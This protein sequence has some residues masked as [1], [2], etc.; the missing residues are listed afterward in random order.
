VVAAVDPY[1]LVVEDG[2]LHLALPLAEG[3]EPTATR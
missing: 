2:A 1:G 3:R